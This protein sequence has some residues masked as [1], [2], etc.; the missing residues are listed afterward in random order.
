MI[1]T[2]LSVFQICFA[3]QTNEIILFVNNCKDIKKYDTSK[4]IFSTHIEKMFIFASRK[5]TRFT[6]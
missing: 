6:A 5:I 1:K 3:F 4:N 2:I